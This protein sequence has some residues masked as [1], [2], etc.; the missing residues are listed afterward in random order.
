MKNK[1]W[2]QENKSPALEIKINIYEI[3]IPFI[4]ITCHSSRLLYNQITFG[5]R[6]KRLMNID[7]NS[8]F[9]PRGKHALTFSIRD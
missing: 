5:G 1:R 4:K 8:N 2:K 6:M 7:V 9:C 3:K